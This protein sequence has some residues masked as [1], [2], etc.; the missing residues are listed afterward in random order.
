MTSKRKTTKAA[1][2]KVDKV[3]PAKPEQLRDMLKAVVDAMEA[4][5]QRDNPLIQKAKAQLG[6]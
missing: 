2:V 1:A 6:E 3:V 5:G 4:A